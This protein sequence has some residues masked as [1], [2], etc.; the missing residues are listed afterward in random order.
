MGLIRSE[1]HRNP[2]RKTGFLHSL[3]RIGRSV[4]FVHLC[5]LDLADGKLGR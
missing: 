3:N 1:M 4:G 5:I 2:H